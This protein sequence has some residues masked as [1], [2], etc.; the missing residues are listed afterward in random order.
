LANWLKMPLQ[1][2]HMAK[3]VP[4]HTCGIGAGQ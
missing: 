3:K 1:I 4:C 2:P